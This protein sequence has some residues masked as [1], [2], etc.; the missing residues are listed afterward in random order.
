MDI[1][2]GIGRQTQVTNDALEVLAVVVCEK[3]GV[4]AKCLVG[5]IQSPKETDD[6]A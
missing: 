3:E 4:R 2:A 6:R 1:K 5:F